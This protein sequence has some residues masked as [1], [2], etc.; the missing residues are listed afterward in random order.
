MTFEIAFLLVGLMQIAGYFIQ[1]CTGFGCAVIAAPVTNGLLG[2][3]EGVPYSTLL[4]LPFMYGLGLKSIKDTSW[5]DL[6]KILVLCAPGLLIG[7][8]LFYR[9]SANTAKVGIGAMVTIIALMNIY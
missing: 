3:A 6:G 2:T 9:I 4:T 7:N 8:Y 5:K 1:G